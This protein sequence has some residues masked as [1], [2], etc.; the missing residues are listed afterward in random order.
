M[1]HDQRQCCPNV[2][3]DVLRVGRPWCGIVMDARALDLR[4]VPFG[5]SVVD[6][7]QQPVVLRHLLQKQQEEASGHGFGLASHRGDEVIITAEAAADLR[8]PQ[9]AGHR[10]RSAGK[11]DAQEQD[12]QPP[13]TVTVQPDRQPLHPFRPFPRKFPVAILGSPVHERAFNNAIVTEEPFFVTT[14]LYQPI[15]RFSESAAI[16][17]KR[18]N[19]RT[20][21]W[22]SRLRFK[23]IWVPTSAS[24][25]PGRIGG[26][27]A[28]CG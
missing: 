27:S 28:F 21:P 15:A 26:D 25:C 5:G 19:T 11:E 10:S 2:A 17:R 12:R 7:Q 14:D 24:I 6:G 8:C 3:V 16:L 20:R 23:G 18:A 4:A 9:P 22:P 1:P 13:A